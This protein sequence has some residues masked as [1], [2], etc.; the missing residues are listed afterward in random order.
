MKVQ[1][2]HDR[3]VYDIHELEWH[4]EY[5]SRIESRLEEEVKQAEK[6]N[7][8]LVNDIELIKENQPLLEE[9]L[10]LENEAIEVIQEKQTQADS[11]LSIAT[12]EMECKHDEFAKLKARAE[13]E[14]KKMAAKVRYHIS[15]KS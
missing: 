10:L 3:C 13:E 4:F 11:Y 5:Q 15:R 2:E 6:L 9:K 12:D 7:S 1:E 14:Q 8:R